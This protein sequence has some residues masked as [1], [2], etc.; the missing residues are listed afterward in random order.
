MMQLMV[1]Q[2][3]SRARR[4][5]GIASFAA[6]A[7]A[8]AA[9]ARA[10]GD[11][12]G[13]VSPFTTVFISTGKLLMDVSKLNP[14]FERPDL[15]ALVPPQ[16]TGFDAI[17]NS[18]YSIGI[19]GYTPVG[20]VLLG[21]EWHYSD[22]GE[23]SSTFGK[24]NRLETNYAMAT[25]GFAAWTG[26]RWTLYPFFGVGVGSVKLTL[27][28]RFGVPQ[29]PL[30]QDPSF[31]EIVLSNAPERTINGSY[32]MIQPGLGFDYLALRDDKSHVGLVLGLRFSTAITPNRTTWTYQGRSVYGAPDAAPVGAMLRLVFGVGGFRMAK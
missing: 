6:A 15:L 27:R 8:P 30:T 10:Q 22:L 5:A 29:A 32:V 13:F 18:G 14:R 19:G 23:E 7:L 24:T 31:D 16:H 26:W 2:L 21:G 20:R 11:G 28:D 4:A 3:P 1:A 25:V 17:S 12:D 9:P